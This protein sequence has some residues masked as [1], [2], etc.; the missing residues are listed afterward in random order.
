MPG[1]TNPPGEGK[2][3][4]V[5]RANGVWLPPSPPQDFGGLKTIMVVFIAGIVA[6]AGICAVTIIRDARQHHS[7]RTVA[8]VPCTCMGRCLRHAER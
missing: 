5:L 6:C 2:V 4:K 1:G 8:H 7:P 3:M